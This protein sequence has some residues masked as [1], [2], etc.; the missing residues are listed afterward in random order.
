MHFQCIQRMKRMDKMN[1]TVLLFV[2]N[3]FVW[4]DYLLTENL[5]KAAF[6]Y[7]QYDVFS[8]QSI[9]CFDS[10]KKSNRYIIVWIIKYCRWGLEFLF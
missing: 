8:S 7:S 3:L 1:P 4:F 6:S 5:M 10:E 2:Q 9:H